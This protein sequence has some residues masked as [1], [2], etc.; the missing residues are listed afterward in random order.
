MVCCNYSSL[1]YEAFKLIMSL[2]E[3]IYHQ[4]NLP[5]QPLD[6]ASGSNT[7]IDRDPWAQKASAADTLQGA[8][9]KDVH[10]GIGQPFGG[11][12][13]AELHHD[14]NQHRKRNLQG[15]G[16]YGDAGDL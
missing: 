12:T 11:Q 10:G 15:T 8:T 16:Q 4:T 13:S 7:V 3:D 6:P 1:R 2:V 14:G 5:P 9:S